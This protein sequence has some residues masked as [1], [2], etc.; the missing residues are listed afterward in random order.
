[1]TL[2]RDDMDIVKRLKD[3]TMLDN[4]INFVPFNI[5]DTYLRDAMP[6]KLTHTEIFTSRASNLI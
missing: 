4:G 5:I 1:M 3:I 2:M 6:G